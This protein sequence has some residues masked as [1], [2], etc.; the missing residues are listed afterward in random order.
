MPRVTP[1]SPP[2]TEENLRKIR[3]AWQGLTEAVAEGRAEL[4]IVRH[5]TLFTDCTCCSDEED[6]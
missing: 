4:R 5:E 6:S 1:V 3:E 2:L